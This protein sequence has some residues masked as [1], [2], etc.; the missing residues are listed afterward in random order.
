M[1][2]RDVRKDDVLPKANAGLT[3]DPMLGSVTDVES[4]QNWVSG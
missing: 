4:F 1:S 2:G 3:I